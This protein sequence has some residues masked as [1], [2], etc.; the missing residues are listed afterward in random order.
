MAAVAGK[1]LDRAEDTATGVRTADVV[2][3]VVVVV[4][5]AGVVC[6]E[7]DETFC[8]VGPLDV[9]TVAG[10]GRAAALKV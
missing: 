9:I 4:R 5:V 1:I 2:C 6:T 10:P 8:M 3:V 7:V